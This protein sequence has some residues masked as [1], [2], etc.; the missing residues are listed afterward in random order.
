[1]HSCKRWP[2]Q[3]LHLNCFSS[4]GKK[5]F[6]S[7]RGSQ[8]LPQRPWVFCARE[9]QVGVIQGSWN[10]LLSLSSD[11]WAQTLCSG[12]AR[13]NTIKAQLVHPPTVNL[14]TAIINTKETFTFHESLKLTGLNILYPLHLIPRVSS[15]KK[16]TYA[17][18]EP[19]TT[20]HFSIPSQFPLFLSPTA[21]RE[22]I[23]RKGQPVAEDFSPS[24]DTLRL[25]CG[26][27]ILLENYF[28]V[29]FSI[30]VLALDPAPC[31]VSINH[32]PTLYNSYF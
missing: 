26:F 4:F 6:T 30:H 29:F 5:P 7:F 16:H 13:K 11:H 28:I 18:E 8:R 9:C 22:I 31:S 14:F 10:F 1:M 19:F 24:L 17:A 27:C 25:V 20:T 12:V 21:P 23:T 15:W 32:P 3:A 2:Y